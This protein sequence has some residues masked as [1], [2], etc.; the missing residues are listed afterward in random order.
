MTQSLHTC[1]LGQEGLEALEL[2][3]DLVGQVVLD[4]AN[5]LLAGNLPGT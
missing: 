3:V 2:G 1:L 5:C 4:G